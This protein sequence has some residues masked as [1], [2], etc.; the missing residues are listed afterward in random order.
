MNEKK[1]GR[2]ENGKMGRG[3]SSELK[4]WKL[5]KIGILEGWKNGRLEG[6]RIGN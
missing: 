5:G 4:N 2:R 3:L 6:I 1:K